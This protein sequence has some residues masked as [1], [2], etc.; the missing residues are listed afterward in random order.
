MKQATVLLTC[1]LLVFSLSSCETGRGIKKD[2]REF[3]KE[4]GE[5]FSETG[6]ALKESVK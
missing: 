6:K 2:F 3:G 5:G 4:L 1:L